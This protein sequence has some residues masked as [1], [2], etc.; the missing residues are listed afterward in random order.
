M[1]SSRCYLDRHLLRQLT[2]WKLKLQKTNQN[3]LNGRRDEEVL[4]LQSQLLPLELTVVRIQDARDGF[5]ATTALESRRVVS[6][7]EDVQIDL[8]HG[9]GL[10]QS[11]DVAVVRLVPRDR[12][13]VGDGDDLLV[14]CHLVLRWTDSSNLT[15]RIPFS[16]CIT[17]F[18]P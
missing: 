2:P 9:N 17:Q 18:P 15:L 5:R 10:P 1:S 13:V 14:V 8:V 3:V 7:V 16:S 4:L 12:R 6:L 11:Q